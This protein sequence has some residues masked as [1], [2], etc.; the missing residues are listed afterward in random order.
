M[1][2]ESKT[3]NGRQI[4]TDEFATFVNC[5]III[6]YF[7]KLEITDY[8]GNPIDLESV[9]KLRAFTRDKELYVWRSNGELRARIRQDEPDSKQGDGEETP[10][11]DSEMLID[12]VLMRQNRSFY[13]LG[14]PK[15]K[16]RNYVRYSSNLQAYFNDIRILEML[17]S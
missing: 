9:V 3:L 4:I 8:D 6:W 12:K 10:Y 16:V 14:S 2:T 17:Q 11:V 15:V 5:K 13:S 1:K 7:D